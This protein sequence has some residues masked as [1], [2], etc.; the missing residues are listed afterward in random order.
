MSPFYT[1]GG[2][3]EHLTDHFE[4]GQP[5]RVRIDFHAFGP[6]A[7]ADVTLELWDGAADTGTLLSTYSIS[8]TFGGGEAVTRSFDWDLEDD[9]LGDHILTA[10]VTATGLDELTLA[11]NATENV[12][13]RVDAP[14]LFVSDHF[15]WP[16]PAGDLEGL[17]IAYRLSRESEGSV[18]LKVF[19]VTGQEIV[20]TTRYYDPSGGDDGNVGLLPGLNS[21][22]W[23]TL[24]EAPSDLASGIYIYQIT[25]YDRS[26]VEPVD[27]VM[28]KFA[29]VR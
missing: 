10:R 17:N 25:L 16:N 14:S 5:A 1:I 11:D 19:D 29:V 15:A 26:G 7:A 2:S 28:G 18:D 21:V 13:V 8:G 27:Q 6:D 12:A 20:S 23:P 9:D 22:G 24:E 3:G 4:I